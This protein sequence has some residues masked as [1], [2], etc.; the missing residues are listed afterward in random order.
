MSGDENGRVLETPD[1]SL[2]S[3][4]QNTSG[5]QLEDIAFELMYESPAVSALSFGEV[6]GDASASSVNLRSTSTRI[7]WPPQGTDVIASSFDSLSLIDIDEVMGEIDEYTWLTTS[8]VDVTMGFSEDDRSYLDTGL[9]NL[10]YSLLNIVSADLNDALRKADEY[11]SNDGCPLLSNAEGEFAQ[12]TAAIRPSLRRQPQV[13]NPLTG[14][15]PPRL[16]SL[17]GSISGDEETHV[18]SVSRGGNDFESITIN[19]PVRSFGGT[20]HHVRSHGSPMELMNTGEFNSS[21]SSL[22]SMH[23]RNE[24]GFEPQSALND[25]DYNRATIFASEL[26]ENMSNLNPMGSTPYKQTQR[27]DLIRGSGSYTIKLHKNRDYGYPLGALAKGIPSPINVPPTRVAPSQTLVRHGVEG[28]RIIDRSSHPA[29]RDP[30][31]SPSYVVETHGNHDYGEP[32]SSTIGGVPPPPSV[33]AGRWSPSYT[34]VRGGTEPSAMERY[35]NIMTTEALSPISRV[36]APTATFSPRRQVMRDFDEG[37][38]RV[39]PRDLHNLTYCED[40]SME[41]GPHSRE[42]DSRTYTRSKKNRMSIGPTLNMLNTTME[43]PPRRTNPASPSRQLNTTISLSPDHNRQSAGSGT[44]GINLNETFDAEDVEVPVEGEIIDRSRVV[45]RNVSYVVRREE[46]ASNNNT[47]NVST[48]SAPVDLNNTYTY[49]D[50]DVDVC[51]ISTNNSMEGLNSRAESQM[52][53][54]ALESSPSQ[55]VIRGRFSD[56]SDRV[57]RQIEDARTIGRTL[58]TDTYSLAQSS[59]S[60]SSD[61]SSPMDTQ[62]YEDLQANEAVRRSMPNLASRAASGIRTHLG[63]PQTGGGQLRK[64]EYMVSDSRL[65]RL[66]SNEGPRLSVMTSDRRNVGFSR[67]SIT[68]GSSSSRATDRNYS[69]PSLNRATGSSAGIAYPP[70]NSE[71]RRETSAGGRPPN[72][73]AAARGTSGLQG[74]RYVG[75]ASGIARP[76]RSSGIPTARGIGPPRSGLPVP[77]Y[78]TQSRFAG[79]IPSRSAA[80]GLLRSSIAQRQTDPA[81]SKDW[82]DGCY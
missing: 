74:P 12:G 66:G 39:S 14:A 64:K 9:M 19:S 10:R 24:P 15:G 21:V 58:S 76:P 54:L 60:T 46:E 78:R 3:L 48:S 61:L 52:R 62:G 59:E 81:K 36:H 2:G 32:G 65:T 82:Q 68:S 72:T 30:R 44:Q 33:H 18:T 57:M 28:Q 67:G 69:N 20:L 40:P 56:Q 53:R 1:V 50:G 7:L 26:S 13:G 25:I 27:E 63:F 71:L 31:A 34:I 42:I 38:N 5:E 43:L 55:G 17:D 45:K 8:S 16:Q 75:P 77:S 80:P 11:P 37:G 29:N 23:S 51:Q 4:C 47:V 73:I 41:D 79:G 49:G 22:A 6:E 70:Q 35:T